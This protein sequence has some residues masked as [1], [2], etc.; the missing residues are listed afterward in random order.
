MTDPYEDMMSTLS[1]RSMS[2]RQGEYYR[3]LLLEMKMSSQGVGT[4]PSMIGLL[5]FPDYML[6]ANETPSLVA[7]IRSN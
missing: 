1:N 4:Q 7:N 5:K 3:S 6:G 2:Q